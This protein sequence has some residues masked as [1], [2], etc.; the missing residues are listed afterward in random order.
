MEMVYRK[1]TKTEEQIVNKL[2]EKDFL[3]KEAIKKQI[4]SALVRPI[5]EYKD[6]YGSLEFKVDFNDKAEVT[7]RI[8]VLGHTKD[9]DGVLVEIF[10]HVIN[11]KINELEIVKADSS[12]IK[13]IL[14][15][16]KITVIT[17]QEVIHEG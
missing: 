16:S 12:M 17:D 9:I 3:G 11:G 10:L 4:S 14:D 1:L 7:N 5:G 6:N 13:S 15:P 8:P 2:L